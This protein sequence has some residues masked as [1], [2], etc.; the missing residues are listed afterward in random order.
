MWLNLTAVSIARGFLVSRTMLPL[1]P[2]L[3]SAGEEGVVLSN[4]IPRLEYLLQ[5]N[6]M[7]QKGILHADIEDISMYLKGGH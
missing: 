4:Q 3:A 7:F 1:T 5:C 6:G 2:G